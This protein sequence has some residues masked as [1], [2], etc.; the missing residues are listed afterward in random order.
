MGNRAAFLI[1]AAIAVLSAA[2]SVRADS[3]AESTNFID[4]AYADLLQRSPSLPEVA[5]GLTSLGG[6]TRFQFAL[7]LDTSSEYYRLLANSYFQDLLGRSPT[8]TE[9]NAFTGLLVSNNPDESIQALLAASAEFYFHGG[10]TDAGF[11]TA[12]FHDFLKRNPTPAELAFWETQLGTM[13]RDQVASLIL[14]SLVYD[15]DLV[16]S[17]YLQFLQR[18]AN[19]TEL[20]SFA[21]D[22]N[23]GTMTD[24][25]VIASLIG[26]DR[27]FQLAQASGQ[28][29]TPEP[30]AFVLLA[31][32]I[33]ALI[34]LRKQ[35]G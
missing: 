32:G 13:T 24:E 7:S 34:L 25:Q 23:G 17:Y 31:L 30:R 10:N 19:S 18:P 4:K 2:S 33:A 28:A 3:I 15:T 1:G 26:T 14:G 27:Y 21:A 29:Q 22:L 11:I 35:L 20:H 8:L 6:Q 5:S 16:Q 9:L 12:L